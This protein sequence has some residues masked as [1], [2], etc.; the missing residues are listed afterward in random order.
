MVTFHICFLV[1]SVAV[2][3]YADKQA[4]QWVTGKR[5]V[6]DAKMLERVHLLMWIGLGGM[7]VT[8][9]IMAQE[10]IA[11]YL[12][13]PYFIAKMAFVGLLFVNGIVIGYL[14]PI[15]STK[16]FVSVP[17]REK[18]VLAMSG[19]ASLGG[20]VGAFVMAKLLFG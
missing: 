17:L 15:A 14:S 16:A 19:A 20:W 1:F 13:Q 2:M 7:I 18:I 5:L 10:H 11:L 4:L 6:L 12:Q 9:V 8:G 3:L